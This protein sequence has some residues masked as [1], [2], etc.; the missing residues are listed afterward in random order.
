MSIPMDKI[1]TEYVDQAYETTRLGRNGV[2]TAHDWV[3]AEMLAE[4]A[5]SNRVEGNATAARLSCGP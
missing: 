2:H 4:L 1:L 5:R 3:S